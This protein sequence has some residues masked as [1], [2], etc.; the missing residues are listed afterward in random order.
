MGAVVAV[1]GKTVQLPDHNYIKQPLGAVLDHTLE[2]GAVVCFGRK[3][4]VDV[5]LHYGHTILL[6][7]FHT[8]SELTVNAFLSLTLAGIT[9][10][11]YCIHIATPL[12][13]SSF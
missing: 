7:I 3:G 10:I 6:T 12:L 11:N 2:V 8:L 4:T 13:I 5:L 9:S 1:A